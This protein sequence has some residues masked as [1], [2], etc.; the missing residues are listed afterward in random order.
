MSRK[1]MFPA[2][3]VGVLAGG[4]GVGWA[5]SR[6]R[7][8]APATVADSRRG[9]VLYQANCAVCHGPDGRGDGQTAATLRPPPRDFAA[10]PWRYEPTPESI[11]RVIR[12][13]IPGTA[14]PAGH[15]MFKPA[16]IDLLTT[17]VHHLATSRP[18]VVYEPTTEERLL[19]AAGFLDIR[20]LPTPAL[21]LASSDGKLLKLVDLKGRWVLINFWG[22]ACEH[23][24]KEMPG[25]QKFEQ[26]HGTL[27]V[28]NVCT[29]ADESGDAQS[30]LTRIVPG[31]TTYVDDSGLGPARFD[32]KSLPTF[33][34]IDP[35]GNAVGRAQ[36][37]KDWTSTA[38]GEL[39][40]HLLSAK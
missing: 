32:V 4:L 33:V 24:L 20:G 5:V 35:A 36:G 11:R 3:L 16:D 28:L 30:I 13:G 6:Q 14:M 17:H 26:K 1:W 31:M 22:I 40:E 8:P 27:T 10:R 37:A 7:A 23:C 15:A 39:F 12:D 9:E 2:L 25:L 18:A 38:I 29:D 19:K 34:L 21:T